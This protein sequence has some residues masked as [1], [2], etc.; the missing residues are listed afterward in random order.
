MS[1]VFF[2]LEELKNCLVFL[3]MLPHEQT[4]NTPVYLMFTYMA[5]PTVI[6]PTFVKKSPAVTPQVHFSLL[7]DLSL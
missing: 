3:Y 2:L 1:V 7:R 6:T 4:G 5:V